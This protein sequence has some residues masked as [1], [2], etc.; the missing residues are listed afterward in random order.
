MESSM[1]V[2][3]I[4]L[5]TIALSITALAA[6]RLRRLIDSVKLAAAFSTRQR[7]FEGNGFKRMHDAAALDAQCMCLKGLVTY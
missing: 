4:G 6:I 1:D 2:P 3:N 7:P 5:S